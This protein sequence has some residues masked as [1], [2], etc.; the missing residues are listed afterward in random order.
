[1]ISG[2]YQPVYDIACLE[3]QVNSLW[4]LF[5]KF[6]EL[7]SEKSNLFVDSFDV[8]SLLQLQL[9]R[10]IQSPA[11]KTPRAT[12]SLAF[13]FRCYNISGGSENLS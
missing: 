13:S 3:V 2:S 1:L 5:Q 8:R 11:I 9:F 12:L 6:P 4:L 10:L 7:Y